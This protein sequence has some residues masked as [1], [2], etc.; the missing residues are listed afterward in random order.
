MIILYKTDEDFYNG[1][2]EMLK[3]GIRFL[4]DAQDLSISLT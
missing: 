3:R 4:A 2:E 1:V